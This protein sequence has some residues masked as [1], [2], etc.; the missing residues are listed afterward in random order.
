MLALLACLLLAPLCAASDPLVPDQPNATTVLTG[1]YNL[2]APSSA[3]DAK[4]EFEYVLIV[5]E[6]RGEYLHSQLGYAAVERQWT[7]KAHLFE[8]IEGLREA[9]EWN[10]GK[11][12]DKLNIVGL[13]R[14]DNL[15]RIQLEYEDVEHVEPEHVRERRWTERVWTITRTLDIVSG[16]RTGPTQLVIRDGGGPDDQKTTEIKEMTDGLVLQR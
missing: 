9:L 14:L 7:Y 1:R 2:V 15:K 16:S 3:D 11:R 10:S 4:P 13:W 5:R 6:W 12:W 8:N